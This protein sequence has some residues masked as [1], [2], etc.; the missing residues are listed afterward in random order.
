MEEWGGGLLVVE[1]A[2]QFIIIAYKF[3]IN[4]PFLVSGC[5]IWW[6]LSSHIN[7]VLQVPRVASKPQ[8]H[9]GEQTEWGGTEH[10]ERVLV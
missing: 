7:F 8:Q 2:N 9:S 6:D 1:S 3:A 4:A 5:R 10:G